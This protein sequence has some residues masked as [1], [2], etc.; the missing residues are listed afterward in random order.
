MSCAR[1]AGTSVLRKIRKRGGR[2]RR[3]RREEEDWKDKEK[4]RRTE[5]RF[6][7]LSEP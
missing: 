4:C 7:F 3:R 1:Q 6:F 5:I 2:R